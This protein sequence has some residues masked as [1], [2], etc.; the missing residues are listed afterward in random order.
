MTTNKKFKIPKLYI[1]VGIISFLSILGLLF[2]LFS[3][4]F[5]YSKIVTIMLLLVAIKFFTINIMAFKEYKDLRK[6]REN[7][8]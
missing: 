8:T 4:N 3:S 5:I 1:G 2:S 7:N 6:R